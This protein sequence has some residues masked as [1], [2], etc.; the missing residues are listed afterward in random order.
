MPFKGS[1][2]N[3]AD[4]GRHRG[5]ILFDGGRLRM[6]PYEFLDL[7]KVFRGEVA[8]ADGFEGLDY[9]AGVPAFDGEVLGNGAAEGDGASAQRN[10]PGRSGDEEDGV[11]GHLRGEAGKDLAHVFIIEFREAVVEEEGSIRNLLNPCPDDVDD[12]VFLCP[13]GRFTRLFLQKYR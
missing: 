1:D 8:F 2:E 12:F 4:P 5:Q 10:L 9:Q 6:V 7:G 13:K 11:H 3:A